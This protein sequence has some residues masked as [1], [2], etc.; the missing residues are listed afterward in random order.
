MPDEYDH[1]REDAD[2]QTS[3]DFL[4]AMQHIFGPQNVIVI[5]LETPT[6]REAIEELIAAATGPGI[7]AEPKALLRLGSAIVTVQ[8]LLD[9]ARG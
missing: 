9:D 3:D 5:G 2:K 8:F 4:E 1:L 7:R 6:L